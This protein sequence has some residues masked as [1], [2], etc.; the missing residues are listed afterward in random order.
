[1]PGGQ[2]GGAKKWKARN[3]VV[4][5]QHTA[6]E[7]D[8]ASEASHSNEARGTGN[9]S[10]SGQHVEDDTS[11]RPD[12]WSEWN[13]DP[14]RR[15]AADNWHRGWKWHDAVGWHRSWDDGDYGRRGA[16]HVAKLEETTLAHDGRWHGSAWRDSGQVSSTRS[17]TTYDTKGARPSEKMVVPEFDGEGDEQELGRSARSYVRK[18]HVWLRC[19]RMAERERPL[20]LYTHLT[21]R[22]WIAAEEL[23]MDRLHEEGGIDYFLDWIRIRFMEIEV[24]K[25][26]TVMTELFRRCRKRADQSVREFNLE[27][28]RLLMHLREL[29]CELPPLVKAWLYLDKLRLAEGDEM[30]LLS[31]VNNRYD[32]KLLQQAALLHDRSTRRPSN[33][34]EKGG[35]S[36]PRWKR[37]STVHLTQHDDEDGEDSDAGRGDD[38][39]EDLGSDEDLVT[40]EVATHYHDAF[41]AYQDA[42]SKYREAVKGRGYDRDEL[43][44]RAEERLR[45]AKARSFCSVC[46]RKGHWHRDPECPMRGKAQTGGG[47]SSNGKS[48]GQAKSVQLCQVAHVFTT[49]TSSLSSERELHAIADTACSRTVAGHDW[50]EKYCDIAETYGI[51]VEI[52]EESEKFRFGASRVHEST[53][54][55]W[56]K[57]AVQGKIFAVK[58]A[59]V[60]CKVP[61]LFSRNVLSRL[62]MVY[63]LEDGV[64]DLE[65][66]GVTA[67]CMGVSETGHPT[68]TVT[69]FG[70]D[71]GRAQALPNAETAYMSTAAEGEGGFASLSKVVNIFYPKKVSKEVQVSDLHESLMKVLAMGCGSD[72][73]VF[74]EDPPRLGSRALQPMPAASTV[75]SVW[76]MGKEQLTRELVEHGVVVH[77]NWTV[78]ELRTTVMEQRE[79]LNP[80]MDKNDKLKGITQLTLDQ[81]TQKAVEEGLSLPPRPTRGL[82]IRMLRESTQQESDNVMCFGKFK[83]WLY[84]EVPR[85]Y[86]KWAVDETAANTNASEDLVRFATWA[87]EEFQKQ[88]KVVLVVRKPPASKDDP[89]VKAK[90]P[91]PDIEVMS[92]ASG[93]SESHRSWRAGRVQAKKKADK[94]RVDVIE[95]TEDMDSELPEE[96]R[97]EIQ[98]MEAQLAAL[99]QKHKERPEG[100]SPTGVDGTPVDAMSASAG[101]PLPGVD[102]TPVGAVK[103]PA[104]NPPPLRGVAPLIGG[105][106][107]DETPVGVSSAPA[108]NSPTMERVPEPEEEVE[109]YDMGSDHGKSRGHGGGDQELTPREK[110]RKGIQMRKKLKEPLRKKVFGMSKALLSVFCTCLVSASGLAEEVFAEPIYDLWNV[111]NPMRGSSSPACLEIFA[112]RCTI[113]GAFADKQYGVLRPRDLK[114]GDDLRCK[115][116]QEEILE[117]IDTHRPRLVWMSPPCT[118]WCGFSNLNYNPQQLRRLRA[119]ERVFLRFIDQVILKQKM[120]GGHAIVENPRKRGESPEEAYELLVTDKAFAEELQRCCPGDHTH[121]RV[122]GSQ[123]AHS[124]GYPEGFGKAVVRAFEKVTAQTAYVQDDGGEEA[125]AKESLGG[126]KDISFTGNVSGRVAGALRRLHQKLGH[127]PNRELAKHLRLSGASQDLIEAASGLKC[128]ACEK[129]ARPPL[130]PVAKPA[131]LLDFN[132]AVA[133]DIIFLDNQQ[134]KGNL[135][136]NMVDIGSSYQVVAPL[137][138]RKSDTVL[139]VFLKYWVNWAGPPGRLVLDLDTAF[140][141]SF[142]DLTSDLAISMRAAA[143]QAHWQNG[144]AERYG[145]SW[146]SCWEKL[147]VAEGIRDED[148]LDAICAVNDARN[149][150]RNRSGFSPR[151]WVFGTNGRLVADLEDGGHEMSA[152]HAVTPE[153]RMA[154]KHALR[155]GARIAF[156]EAQA[157]AAV[158]RALAHKNRTKPKEYKPGDLV[159]YYRQTKKKGK[160][161]SAMWMGP[162]AIIGQEG[163]NYWLARGGRCILAAPEHL[164]AAEHEE[165]S[166]ILR[167]KAAIKEVEGVLEEEQKDYADLR[168]PHPEGAGDV[169]VEMEIDGIFDDEDE[170]MPTAEAPASSARHEKRKKAFENEQELKKV[171]RQ[172]GA[173]DDVPASVKSSLKGLSAATTPEAPG[174]VSFLVKKANSPEGWEKALEK[175]IPWG[176]IP[177]SERHLYIAAEEKQW[178]EHLEF[179]AVKPLT[180]EESERVKTEVDPA[181]IL[182][183]RFLY[184]DK[185]HAKRKIDPNIACKAKARLCVGG[186]RDPD[187]GV[188]EMEVDAPTASRHS[189][190]LGL[191]VA[192]VR[193]WLVSIGDIRAAFLNGV[194]APRSLF[195]KQPARGIPGL[196]PG[197]LIEILKGVF[198]LSTSPKLW[199]IRL[200]SELT[201]ITFQVHGKDYRIIQNDIDPC[202]FQVLRVD[203]EGHQVCGLIFT[204]VDDLMVMADPAIQ[205]RD[206]PLMNGSVIALITWGVNTTSPRRRSTSLRRDMY[207]PDS[208]K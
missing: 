80:R 165:V 75:Q 174:H 142:A 20:A 194:E 51:P 204:H 36:K 29:E 63:R 13:K 138:N 141:D 54:S 101:N 92:W 9:S 191:Q 133:I 175:E 89:E 172:L 130:H 52:V 90:I 27:Y 164:R 68:L 56:A 38:L 162:A 72:A 17:E 107:R 74:L 41:M 39:E 44:K 189:L 186:Q 6:S 106:R 8:E 171:A 170:E 125:T 32:L 190:L 69:D 161:T 113:T 126:G 45:A 153:G 203:G 58:I 48:D 135:A 188:K 127:P 64:A 103:A 129:C 73:A 124:A 19:T 55:V 35:E 166:E 117:T 193:G 195:F 40:E 108:G 159:Y 122:Q 78:P 168:S 177:E 119:R 3:H 184:R 82:L 110:A 197:Q 192:L 31:S 144:I 76:K 183:A 30:S 118:F 59:I 128:R 154:R 157:S 202:V 77:P 91:P 150:L 105:P 1:M 79:A 136:L 46:K 139:R 83:G 140:A 87:K 4:A 196:Q 18:V 102:R 98:H 43:K 10:S 111:I 181:R 156:F 57:C 199:W 11:G 26:A 200:S 34:W 160:Q 137:R 37:Q 95:V 15:Q 88:D 53:F 25:V 134:G 109:S 198:G 97:A 131:A 12:P 187:L 155:N 207:S 152:L 120:Y 201:Q 23:S 50:F 61:L 115:E 66:L 123:T 100:C 84:K 5:E 2:R 96:A 173:L 7:G 85:E 145:S 21:G 71:L 81:L 114:F 112:G 42:K 104:G 33:A 158:E 169:E 116:T 121:V 208:T 179:G 178:K 182:P 148:M 99:K 86:M 176:M 151:Q 163:Q 180:L 49:E 70:D 16:E 67:L 22:A 47:G 94:R 132:E 65:N 185:H 146:K 149:S 167:I 62:G 28:E 60:A 93:S 147:C 206:F 14:W 143:G 205:G 24:T